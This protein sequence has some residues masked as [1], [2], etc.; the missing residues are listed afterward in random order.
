[1]KLNEKNK[2]IELRKQGRSYSDILQIINVSRGTLGRWLK[3][4]L[5]TQEQRVL[6][7]GRMKSR[8]EGA[9]TNQRKAQ[10]R[11]E[12][13]FNSAKKEVKELINNPLF[14]SGLV[15]YWAEGTKNGS[16]VAFT[17]SDPEMIELMMRWFRTICNVPED[18]F[19]ILIFIHSMQV[20]DNWKERW[21]KVT[22]LPESQFIRPYIK[23][24]ITKHRK[25]KLYEGT[26]AIRINDISLLTRIRG[27]Q[28]GFLDILVKD[29]LR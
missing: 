1:M 3:D 6:L 18:K 25:N 19:R 11:K 4:I 7:K 22:G 10:Q 24:T 15:L 29:K 5:L 14:I 8:Y 16:T 23:P 27:W 20:N 26:C 12:K 13:T 17:N 28:K 21:C 9:R 2:A